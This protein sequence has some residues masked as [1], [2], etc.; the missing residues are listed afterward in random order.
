MGY[1][2][3]KLGMDGLD[4]VALLGKRQRAMGHPR[5]KTTRKGQTYFFSCEENLTLFLGSP[6][7]YLPQ[8]DG[9][10]AFRYS[11]FGKMEEGVPS[12]A[13]CINGKF[14]FFSKPL[15]AKICEMCPSLLEFGHERFDTIEV[16]KPSLQTRYWRAWNKLGERTQRMLRRDARGS[17][18]IRPPE[19]TQRTREENGSGRLP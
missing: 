19:T 6:E 11:V 1:F 4:P 10:C 14:Y 13:H 16:K 12:A 18:R 3:S 7:L 2:R 9:H 17:G 8:F 5:W 15:Y